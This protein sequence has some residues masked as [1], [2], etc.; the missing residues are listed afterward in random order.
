MPEYKVSIEIDIDSSDPKEAADIAW[1]A[2]N[3]LYSE[4]G[5]ELEVARYEPSAER[6]AMVWVESTYVKLSKPAD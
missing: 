5:L 3:D 2:F 4:G 1:L 6:D